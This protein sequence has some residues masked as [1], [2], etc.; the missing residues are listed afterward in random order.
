MILHERFLYLRGR[1]SVLASAG[2][3]ALFA[4]PP[5]ADAQV[6]IEAT[7]IAGP[8]NIHIGGMHPV[9][10]Q[11]KNVGTMPIFENYTAEVVLSDD[12]AIDATDPIVGMVTSN[13]EGFQ[14][15]ITEIPLSLPGKPYVWGLRILQSNG[16]LNL[17]NN[18]VLG[19]K[20]NVFLLDIELDDDSPITAFVRAEEDLLEPISVRVNN[21]GT[22]GSIVV[23]N[24][25]SLDPVPPPWLMI[26]PPSSFAIGGLPGNDIL[27]NFDHTLVP[28]GDYT[29][30]LRFTNFQ[31]VTDFEDLVVTLSVGNA[32]FVP[33]HKFQG[34]IVDSNDVDEIVFEGLEGQLLKLRVR[35]MSGNLAPQLSIIDPNDMVEHVLKFKKHVGSYILKNVKLKTSGEYTVRIEGQGGTKG[36]YMVKSG[37]KLPKE[38]HPRKLKVKNPGNGLP[39]EFPV[40]ILKEGTLEW[41]GKPNDEFAGPLA[42]GLTLPSGADFDVTG[43]S[44]QDLDG[45]IKVEGV[46]MSESGEHVIRVSG[47]GAGTDEMVKVFI[48]PVQPVRGKGKI[49]IK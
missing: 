12:L 23:F 15:I 40:R 11:V 2:I 44:T 47:F 24:V 46:E 32:A 31:N 29:T 39:V 18:F 13:I 9:N 28:P 10:I 36:A 34:Q 26:E 21:V 27:L 7:Q 43:N 6:D 8:A 22:P 38:S 37:R 14:Q 3:A 16:E 5:A 30:T 1:V 4:A 19:Q 25:A 45:G 20:V 17:S 33:G 41:S 49:Y 42:F 48:V 35:T